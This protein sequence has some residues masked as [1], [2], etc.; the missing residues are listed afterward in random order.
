MENYENEFPEQ[1]QPSAQPESP[2]QASPFADSPYELPF[3]ETYEAEPVAPAP[4]RKTNT[5]KKI[6]KFLLCSVLIVALVAAGCGATAFTLNR[7]WQKQTAALTQQFN[8][9]IKDLQEEIKDNSFTGNGNSVSGT[10]NTSTDG[11]TPGQVYAKCAK[12]VVAIT[13]TSNMGSSTGSGFIL[14]AD[15]YVLT[16]HHVIENSSWVT[17]TIYDNTVHTA[18]VIGY[19]DTNDIALLKI[20]G[21]NLPTASL[22]SSNDLIVGDQVV[23]IGNPLG[24]LTSTLTV[25]YI[26]AKERDVA[27]DGTSINMLQ[28]DAAINSGNSGGPLFNMNGQVIGI[29]TAKY[30]GSTSS[31]ATIEGIGFAIPIDDVRSKIQQ[32]RENGYVSTPYMGV[33]VSNRVTGYGAYVESVEKDGAAYAAGIRAGDLIMSVGESKVTSV[34]TLTKALRNYKVGDATTVTVLRNQRVLELT[35]TLKE[36]PHN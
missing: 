17:V 7:Y 32:L 12:S 25:G 6:A 8:A 29:I 14:T 19:D 31:G 13:A 5:G 15:G 3:D 21:E 27:T 11:M 23:A 26:S 9:Q 20:D 22:G 35:L 36:K 34:E 28:T 1:E 33:S 24:E 18:K 16:N 4:V 2:K 30:S 10:P